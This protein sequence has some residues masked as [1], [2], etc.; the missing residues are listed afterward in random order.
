M[1]GVQNEREGKVLA[2]KVLEREDL[3][4]NPKFRDTATRSDNRDELEVIISGIFS[5]WDADEVTRRLEEA[6]IANAKVNDMQGVWEHPQLEARG[7][8]QDVDSEVGRIKALLPPGMSPDVEARM[9][10][11][12]SVGEHNEGILRELGIEKE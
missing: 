6:G 4:T 3:T 7:R 5:Q 8:W 11:I 12:P 10:R 2:T 9:D 1:L